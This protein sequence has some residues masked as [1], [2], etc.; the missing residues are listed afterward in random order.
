MKKKEAAA[1][2]A[3]LEE[4]KDYAN[5]TPPSNPVSKLTKPPPVANAAKKT[6]APGA[7]SKPAKAAKKTAAPGATNKA[8]NAAKKT[9]APTGATNK[10]A[11]A[12]GV[13]DPNLGPGSG[14]EPPQ[15]EQGCSRFIKPYATRVTIQ[16]GHRIPEPQTATLRKPARDK[17]KIV[18]PQTGGKKKAI[19]NL[20]T[21]GGFVGLCNLANL[22]TEFYDQPARPDDPF[23]HTM[24]DS[25]TLHNSINNPKQSTIHRGLGRHHGRGI[26]TYQ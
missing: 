8:A 18:T 11:N 4:K 24:P 26:H 12:A 21:A 10:P 3:R 1:S 7:T 13:A 22:T 16:L 5:S 15:T 19:A 9:A 14:P 20:T 2:A 23:L 17:K 25:V 6:A